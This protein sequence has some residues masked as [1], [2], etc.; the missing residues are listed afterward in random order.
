MRRI[1]RKTAFSYSRVLPAIMPKPPIVLAVS[2][3]RR[4]LYPTFA[5]A[6]TLTDPKAIALVK[7]VAASRDPY[8]AVFMGKSS[9]DDLVQKMSAVEGTGVVGRITSIFH[10]PND[11]ALTIHIYP[12]SRCKL[13]AI[14]ILKL[15]A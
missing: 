7:I 3:A 8:L 1:L 2:T 6:I 12:Q 10:Q 14:G 15:V 11:T 9:S 13:V 5:Q 4:P